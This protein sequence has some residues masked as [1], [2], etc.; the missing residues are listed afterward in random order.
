MVMGEPCFEGCGFK[1]KHHILDG[2][3]PHLFGVK[4]VKFV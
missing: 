4:I 2:H 1:T 3:F